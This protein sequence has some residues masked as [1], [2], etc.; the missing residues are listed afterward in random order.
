MLN[1]ATE[2]SLS[3]LM[4]KMLRHTPEDFRLVLDPA[5]GSCPVD[6]L[7]K[8]IRG[9]AKWSRVSREDIEQVVRN[10]D[11]QRFVI[12]DGR[13]R[14]RYGHSHD[15]VTYTPGEPPAVLYHGTNKIALPSILKEGLHPMSRQYVHLSEGTHFATLAGSRRG[16][17][18]I[19]KIDTREAGRLGVT[20]YY[21]G[22][23]V[24]L[25]DRVPPECCSVWKPQTE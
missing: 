11:K 22:N 12:E 21:A 20:F 3:K 5:D 8:A 1:P 7:L 19:L 2:K 10:S 18:V 4:S 15:R 14:A 17:L 9:Q 24:W 13:I 25:A 16:E 6:S 23:E